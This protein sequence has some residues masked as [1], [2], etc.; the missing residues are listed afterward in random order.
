[1][2]IR[3]PASPRALPGLLCLLATAFGAG[4]AAR[5]RRAAAGP[6]IARGRDRRPAASLLDP[7]ARA[8]PGRRRPGAGAARLQRRRP[9]DARDDRPA[10]R[11]SRLAPA[12]SSPT[13]TA[14]SGTGTTAVAARVMR[15][16]VATSTI[17]AS[18]ASS[19]PPSSRRQVDPRRVSSGLLER[20]AMALRLALEDAPHY[21]AVAAIG[22]NLPAPQAATARPGRQ[23]CRSR[24]SSARP[25]PST[26]PRRPGP[27]RRRHQP[28]L[29]ARR[30]VRR[31]AGSRPVRASPAPPLHV[32]IRTWIAAIAPAPRASRGSSRAPPVL[33]YVIENGG[34]TI[35]GS[36]DWPAWHRRR[37]PTA[38]STPRAN[39]GRFERVDA[40][41]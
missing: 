27:G 10:A 17:R 2:H 29:R 1:M 38:T 26:V 28:R 19:S 20:R 23:R 41:R 37:S 7:P 15:P 24:C 12:S 22:A 6:G 32:T 40:A 14:S 8:T 13:P 36:P 4:V 21:A 33:L 11:R 35:P 39:P 16:I 3:S 9:A 31:K 30:L 18:C 34:H 5:R 25:I